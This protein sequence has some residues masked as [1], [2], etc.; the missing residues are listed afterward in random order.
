MKQ[1][2]TSRNRR[3]AAGLTIVN[4]AFAAVAQL[5]GSATAPGE[6]LS[7]WSHHGHCPIWQSHNGNKP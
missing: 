2:L 3:L 6:P 1:Q 7:F 5:T 4:I